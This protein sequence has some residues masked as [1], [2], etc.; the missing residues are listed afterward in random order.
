MGTMTDL[1]KNGVKNIKTVLIVLIQKDL[2]KRL[3]VKEKRKKKL[4]KPLARHLQ[5]NTQHLYSLSRPQKTL[6]LKYRKV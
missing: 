3:I 6:L 2:V 4:L 1:K 5:D